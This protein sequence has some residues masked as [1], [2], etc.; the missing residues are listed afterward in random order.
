MYTKREKSLVGQTINH[1][2]VIGMRHLAIGKR[3]YDCE[4]L[5]CGG[6]TALERSSLVSA[7]KPGNKSSWLKSGCPLCTNSTRGPNI[8]FIN[9]P[10]KERQKQWSVLNEIIL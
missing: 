1:I 7:N 8:V 2:K 3:I 5:K 9:T 4:C 10:A 6:V